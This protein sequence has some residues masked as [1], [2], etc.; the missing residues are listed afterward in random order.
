M[1]L[2]N[3]SIADTYINIARIKIFKSTVLLSVSLEYALINTDIKFLTD[4][5]NGS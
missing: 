4:S 5:I 1:F 2:Q 3:I